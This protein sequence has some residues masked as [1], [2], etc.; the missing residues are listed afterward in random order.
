[1][2]ELPEVETIIGD[3]H[4]AGIEGSEITNCLVL[5]PKTVEKHS[6]S[7]FIE[8][9]KGKIIN[10]ISRRGKY[11]VFHLSKN[12][13]IAVHLRMTGRFTFKELDSTINKHEHLILEL[14]SQRWLTYHDTR[15]F[16]RWTC[17]NDPNEF[18]KNM[19]P[20]P[21]EET[22]KLE[23]FQKALEKS[24]RKL[25]PLLLDQSFIAGLGNIYVDE[26]LWEANLHPE[27]TSSALN[28]VQSSKLFKAIKKVLRKG[29]DSQGTTLGTGKTNYY[30]LDGSRGK[31][32]D[33]LHVFRKTGS[34]C[35]RCGSTIV[36]LIVAQRSTHICPFCQRKI[37]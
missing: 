24:Q 35:S 27:T 10:K 19:G 30:R 12:L 3:L 33:V 26:A 32:Q 34:P 11:L 25:K 7:E 16:G 15:K 9:I 28:S 36:R 17:F 14:N 23:N 37:A 8:A 22:F 31:H 5:Y 20:E 13:F 29:I 1:M 21:L 18:F 4:Q 6:P 2:P